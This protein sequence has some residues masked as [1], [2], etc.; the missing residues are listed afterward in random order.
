MYDADEFF[1]RKKEPKFSEWVPVTERL[2]EKDG[3]YL[4]CEK[5]DCGYGAIYN[6]RVVSYSLNL[7]KV[8]KYDFHGKEYKR[9]GWFDY[10]SEYGHF[11]TG[12]DIT[13]WMPLPTPPKEV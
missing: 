13:H 6:I 3:K 2:P 11:E 9:P 5:W 10:D 8:D 12:R 7:N 4:V 1:G